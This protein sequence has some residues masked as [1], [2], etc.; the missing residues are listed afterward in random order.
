MA[1]THGHSIERRKPN[2]PQIGPAG[3]ADG[4]LTRASSQCSI[5]GSLYQTQPFHEEFWARRPAA[6]V[7]RG[8][9]GHNGGSLGTRFEKSRQ[10]PRCCSDGVNKNPKR[11][12]GVWN[13]PMGAPQSKAL[14]NEFF[15][16]SNA[17]SNRSN[18]A[19][20]R[21]MLPRSSVVGYGSATDI[22]ILQFN[23]TSVRGTKRPPSLPR[24]FPHFFLFMIDGRI[25]QHI[26]RFTTPTNQTKPRRAWA[27][28]DPRRE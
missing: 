4:W 12:G 27:R 8:Q 14:N 26:L 25:H 20:N 7:A 13:D 2:P 19:S 24:L 15:N 28:E 11:A 6:C 16:R 21:S 17:A 10:R 9:G 18:A 22:T 1:F 23:T 5:S 3:A